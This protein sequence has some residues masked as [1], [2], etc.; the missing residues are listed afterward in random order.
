MPQDELQELKKA[1]EGLLYPSETDAPFEPFRWGGGG[2]D[3]AR[4][5]V[6]GHARKKQKIEEVAVDDFFAELEGSED[7]ERFRQLRKALESQLAGL[8]VFRVG[9]IRVDIYLIGKTRG[10]EWG[11]LHTISVET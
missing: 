7:A 2:G 9:S 11:G 6:A 3:S 4:D 5:Q 1:S 10:G 8:K